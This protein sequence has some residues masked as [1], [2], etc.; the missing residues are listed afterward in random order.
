MD[1]D[2]WLDVRDSELFLGPD[3]EGPVAYDQFA[4]PTPLDASIDAMIDDASVPVDEGLPEG[5][6]GA[7]SP[8]PENECA[9]VLPGPGGLETCDGFDQDCDGVVDER[10]EWATAPMWKPIVD[11][12]SVPARQRWARPADSD[13]RCEEEGL[14]LPPMELGDWFRLRQQNGVANRP[15]GQHASL[16]FEPID[17]FRMT[18]RV[19]V[20][21]PDSP[22]RA[23]DGSVFP[24]VGLRFRD[25]VIG[26]GFP[27]SMTGL[28]FM[29]TE[30]PRFYYQGGPSSGGGY[31]ETDF[32]EAMDIVIERLGN[33]LTTYVDGEAVGQLTVPQLDHASGQDDPHEP[34]TTFLWRVVTA[35]GVS[36]RSKLR[37]RL[38]GQR[39]LTVPRVRIFF[40]TVLLDPQ[41]MPCPMGG[42]SITKYGWPMLRGADRPRVGRL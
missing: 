2:A 40:G 19:T 7:E 35:T 17:D 13:V 36:K 16:E 20:L 30:I 8:L 33:R 18:L 28:L 27:G 37:C 41:R 11:I 25:E 22:D 14:V 5:D 24:Y 26:P 10:C 23:L 38:T 1:V 39:S 29:P 32:G 15:S 12:D 34:L 6:M 21:N 42:P 9:E 4:Q 31:R 3:S